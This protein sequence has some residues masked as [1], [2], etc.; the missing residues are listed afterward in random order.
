MT[1]GSHGIFACI[2]LACYAIL[3]FPVIMSAAQHTSKRQSV[4]LFL[5]LFT[6]VVGGVDRAPKESTGNIDHGDCD[7]GA[8]LLK[9]SSVLFLIAFIALVYALMHFWSS[10]QVIVDIYWR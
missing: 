3:L 1:L 10:R 5:T 8:K 9:A 4:W 6:L 7:Q 2:E